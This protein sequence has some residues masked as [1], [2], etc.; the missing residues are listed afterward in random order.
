MKKNVYI[1]SIN[2]IYMKIDFKKNCLDILPYPSIVHILVA[3][4]YLF[5]PFLNQKNTTK[6]RGGSPSPPLWYCDGFHVE[7]SARPGTIVII[8][9]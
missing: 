7:D 2:N 3:L 5:P 6:R 9:S 8:G 4:L 1:I